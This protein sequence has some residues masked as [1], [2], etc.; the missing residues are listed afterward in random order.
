VIKPVLFGKFCLLE[1]IS[2]GGMAEVFRAKTLD[3]PDFNRLF[4]IKRILPNLSE[5]SEF[6]SMFIDEA[7]I[8]VQLTHRNVAQIY[9]LGQLD[10]IYYIV[11]EFVSGRDIL[12]IQNQ[13]RRDKK[14]MSVGQACYLARQ[15]ALG[16]DFAHRKT[17]PDGKPLNVIHR[18]ISPQN[19]LV[20][21]TGEVKVIDFG[22]AK[23]ATRSNK[24]QVGVLKG[25][26]GYMS[27]EQVRGKDLDHRSDIFALGTL[28]H[29][30][31][32]CRRLF[33]GESDFAILEKVRKVDIEPPSVYNKNVPPEIDAIVMKAL[34]ADP[35]QRYQWCSELSDDLREFMGRLRPPYTERTLEGWMQKTFDDRLDKERKKIQFF[36]QFRTYEDV[37]AYSQEVARQLELKRQG[38]DLELEEAPAPE[39]SAQATMIWD[40]QKQGLF[41]EEN[42]PAKDM[43]NKATQIAQ[44]PVDDPVGNP[45]ERVLR[46][47]PPPP[48]APTIPGD[49]VPPSMQHLYGTNPRA[50]KPSRPIGGI[51]IG[52]VVAFLALG[53]VGGGVY[54]AVFTDVLAGVLSSANTLIITTE[55]TQ[56]VEVLINGK[57]SATRTPYIATEL[58]PGKYTVE[59]RHPDYL[60]ATKLVD[61]TG[62]KIE[63]PIT[64]TA[65][66]VGTAMVALEIDPPDAEVWLDGAQQD[67]DG[68]HREFKVD[69]QRTHLIELRKR[70][71]F[72]TDIRI[73]PTADERVERNLKLQKV[74]GRI[75]L[76]SNPRGTIHLKGEKIGRAPQTLSDLAPNMVHEVEIRYPGYK[77]W[78]K[79]VIFERSYQKSYSAKLRRGSDDEQADRPEVG[80]LAVDSG[81]TWW[82]V[83]ANGFD[84]GFTTPLAGD[85]KL[86]LSSGEHTI[87]FVRGDQTHTQQVRIREG[88]TVELKIAYSFEW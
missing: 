27:P 4:A 10:E 9:E 31:L 28:F 74:V 12:A 5:D 82:K 52:V 87:T 56:E 40:A 48:A 29:E 46:A 70:G 24:T 22:I 8:S 21:Y 61:A 76:T 44:I 85:D 50:T 65:R 30:M 86:A 53:L 69:D 32:T 64:L 80:Y 17:G 49:F 39:M 35:E 25:K 18:D 68:S 20:S 42:D 45:I 77:T 41:D 11:M 62:G 13:L 88:E 84:T 79:F 34:A 83:M 63:V 75:E 19:I 14:I 51:I 81:P 57:L 78:K 59:V 58:P 60:P 72:V 38:F 71:Y 66:P 7:K 73:K 67:G 36:A 26:F 47:G 33:H 55:P 6:I 37:E 54:V 1:R 16:L 23:A 2:V 3:S 15:I 43:A